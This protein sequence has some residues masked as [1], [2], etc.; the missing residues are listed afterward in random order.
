MATYT[1]NSTDGLSKAIISQCEIMLNKVAVKVKERVDLAL[2]Q[3]Y[4]EYHPEARSEYTTLYYHRTNQLRKC[5]KIKPII[6]GLNNITVEIYLDVESLDYSAEGADHWKTVI[7]AD[8]GLHGGFEFMNKKNDD[9]SNK[10]MFFQI[11]FSSLN[12]D[13]D[14][15]GTRIWHDP[16][17]EL[18][19][20]G[21][22][23]QYFLEEARKLNLNIIAK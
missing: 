14:Y 4:D 9:G 16:M 5:C 21:K 23:R 19:N 8:A 22:L 2:E 13:S 18:L 15:K 11:P 12:E 17:E 20:G 6:K 1:V 10:E 7:A 3:Y